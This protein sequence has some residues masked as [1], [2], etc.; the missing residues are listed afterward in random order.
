MSSKIKRFFNAIAHPVISEWTFFLLMLVMWGPYTWQV[1]ANCLVT[2]T[3]S[4]P[5]YNRL[6]YFA[7]YAFLFSYV[8]TALVCLVRRR[9]LKGFFYAISVLNWGIYLFL[10]FNFHT[11]ITPDV[12]QAMFET[13][14]HEATEFWRQYSLS[15][16]S[17][18]A[19]I[20]TLAMVAIIWAG[21]RWLKRLT[22]EKEAPWL[23]VVLSLILA[24][25]CYCLKPFVSMLRCQTIEQLESC[26]IYGLLLWGSDNL[27]NA[28]YSLHAVNLSTDEVHHA[29]AQSLAELSS[30]LS[31][32]TQ[33]DSLTVVVVIGETYIKSHCALYG[34]YLDT[35]P[36]LARERHKG[37][38]WVFDDV[39]SPYNYTSSSVKNALFCNSLGDGERWSDCPTLMAVM[40]RAGYE[41]MMW[42]NQLQFDKDA[43]F[44]FA[45]NGLLYNPK[46][47][48]ACY[49]AIAD[50]CFEY[51]EQLV[52]NYLTSSWHTTSAPGRLVVFHLMGQHFMPSMR[53]PQDKWSH[54]TGDS[55]KTRQPWLT[56][57]KRAEIA[58]YDNATR[59]NDHVLGR[60][61]N[62]YRNSNAVVIYFADH[63]EEVY[64][65]R[66][67]SGRDES[68]DKPVRAIIY[69]NSVPMMV[70]CSDR[71]RQLYPDIIKRLDNGRR[72]PFMHDNICQVIFAL[73][74]VVTPYYHPERDPLNAK[75]S[76]VKRIV[77]DRID[78]DSLLRISEPHNQQYRK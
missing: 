27:T 37:S 11:T 71:Y 43:V 58:A 24:A 72:H 28:I 50:S 42:D 53:Y 30:G 59:Y 25:N 1:L 60:I 12:L 74:Q 78:Y 22:A 21:E 62:A 67:F 29:I 2:L 31:Y 7:S 49:T 20:G 69:Q 8:S 63:G 46:M 41:V 5:F 57:E 39:I 51:D 75:F 76:G 18:L 34:Y 13:N 36:N 23:G 35:T 10:K 65:W 54:F 3:W 17:C 61:I 56:P 45:L 70:W 55:I 64:D 14:N 38:L 19:Y 33:H 73:A 4:S 48:Q 6:I 26:E 44:S 15:R 32:T 9:W 16:G 47:A 68:A 77:Y 52:D 66:D 40:R